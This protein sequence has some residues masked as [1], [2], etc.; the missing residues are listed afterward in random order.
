MEIKIKGKTC[1]QWTI[2]ELKKALIRRKE[3][4]SGN[5]ADLC[6]RLKESLKHPINKTKTK[7]IRPASLKLKPITL[8]DSLFRFYSSM[9]YQKPN[10]K[11]PLIELQKYGLSKTHLNKFSNYKALWKTF[12]LKKA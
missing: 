2:T 3:K 4:T 8:N 1:S 9:Y 6:L 5:K 12:N 7:I 11:L 10:S